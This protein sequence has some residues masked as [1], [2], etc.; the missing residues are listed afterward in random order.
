MPSLNMHLPGHGHSLLALAASCLLLTGTA[1]AAG[2]NDV[3]FFGDS[4]SD[5]GNRHELMGDKDDGLLGG[6][7]DPK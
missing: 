5:T 1:G 3:V 7:S 2:F 6:L 4:L